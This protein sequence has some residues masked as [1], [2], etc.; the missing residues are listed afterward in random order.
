[1]RRQTEVENAGTKIFAKLY[2]VSEG[3]KHPARCRV[4]Y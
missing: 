2:V 4:V 1:M 3:V